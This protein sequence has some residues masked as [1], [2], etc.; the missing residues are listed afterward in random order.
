MSGFM[1]DVTQEPNGIFN[2]QKSDLNVEIANDCGQS[3]RNCLDRLSTE[4]RLYLISNFV[5]YRV[6]TVPL[7][8]LF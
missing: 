6:P 7:S 8:H 5:F 1:I 2:F 3:F 4:S